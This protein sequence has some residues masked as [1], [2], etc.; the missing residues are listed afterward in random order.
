[1]ENSAL[2]VTEKA[3]EPL[4]WEGGAASVGSGVF[5]RAG[6]HNWGDSVFR[7]GHL[8]YAPSSASPLPG[9]VW[10]FP[11]RKH[12]PLPRTFVLFRPQIFQ[13]GRSSVTMASPSFVQ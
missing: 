10:L 4:G 6:G 2:S 13:G 7:T 8:V 1:M 12:L 9:V 11:G 5:H 3:G